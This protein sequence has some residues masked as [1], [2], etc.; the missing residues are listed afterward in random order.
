MDRYNL[1][2]V[3]TSVTRRFRI[4]CQITDLKSLLFNRT[5][6]V[7]VV[8]IVVIVVVVVVVEVVVVVV[9]VLVVRPPALLDHGRGKLKASPLSSNLYLIP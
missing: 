4:K 1:P 6:L 8:I 2:D 9:V 3:N 5:Y 7:V